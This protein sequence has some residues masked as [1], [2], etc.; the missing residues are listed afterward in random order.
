MAE[1]SIR[2][3]A[4][5]CRSR[6]AKRPSS[7]AECSTRPRPT[8]SP[9]RSGRRPTRSMRKGTVAATS[10]CAP[11]TRPGR[12]DPRPLHRRDRAGPAGLFRAQDRRQGRLCPGKG[13]RNAGDEA[14]TGH[15]SL[16]PRL[17]VS[18][19]TRSHA[20]PRRR[21]GIERG[22]ARSSG[23]E[24]HLHPQPRPRPRPRPWNRRPRLLCSGAPAPGPSPSNRPFHWTFWRKPLR[25]AN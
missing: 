17:R 8:T 11:D 25:R 15:R 13:R 16:S 3:R 10:D 1:R 24:G 18:A 14:E 12:S 19:R 7:P 2:S 21:G 20:E 5:Y 22:D 9:S 23:F 4:G 6:S